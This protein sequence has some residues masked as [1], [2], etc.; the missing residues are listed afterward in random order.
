[1]TNLEKVVLVGLVVGAAVSAVGIAT[2]LGA[3]WA[4]LWVGLLL[5]AGA[6]GLDARE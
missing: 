3:G 5:I 6:L 4:E 2:A 1:M